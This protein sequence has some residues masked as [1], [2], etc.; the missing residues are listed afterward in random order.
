MKFIKKYKFML[1]FLLV[2]ISFFTARLTIT[3]DSAHYMSYVEIFEGVK[4]FSSWDIV[5][6]PIFPLFIFI[7]NVLFGK[8]A[9]GLLTLIFF[10]YLIYFYIIYLI[11]KVIFKDVRFNKYLSII[12]ALFCIFNPLIFGYFHT[13][14]TE[15]FAITLMVLCCYLS[16]KW[17][18]IRE[19]RKKIFY[20]LFFIFS[21]SFSYFLKQPFIC[22]VF[23]PLLISIIICLI[24][25]HTFK[26][27]MYRCGTMIASIIVL[28]TCIICWNRFLIY[29]NVDMNTGRD[30]SSLLTGQ[31]LGAVSNF[32]LSVIDD[33]SLIENDMSL[34]KNERNY[35][36]KLFES[37]KKV[38]LIKIFDND[39]LVESDLILVNDNGS[40]VVDVVKELVFFSFKH[41]DL[42]IESY[43]KNY[44]AISSICVIDSADGVGYWITNR[45][46]FI[47]LFENNSIAYK[48]LKPG[49]NLF[50]LSPE[51]YESAKYYEQIGGLSITS[52]I[53]SIL[54]IPTNIMYKL[55]MFLMPL[56]S[57][58]FFAFTFIKRKTI[59]KNDLYYF[60]IVFLISSF[61]TTLISSST[62]QIIDRYSVYCFIP[63]L[64]GIIV[65]VR[66]CISNIKLRK[67]K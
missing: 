39:K 17:I 15:F 43:S 59:I 50:Y 2:V 61:L 27:I 53:L 8:N 49:S 18:Y 9:I 47:N 38:L 28:F 45:M 20:S 46:E 67:D 31:L 51:K 35:A 30:S 12:F 23:I 64:V 63:G 44:C 7:G 10:V 26:N 25:S 32:N 52:R 57:V 33:Y 6:G 58:L 62:G 1:L 5:R 4:P 22:V 13:L 54:R 34:S 19:K 65:C 42:L 41:P 48:F 11:S 37:N 21:L 56:V 24:K 60:G 55:V 66:F 16:W 3:W 36:K 29:K 14:L 40:S